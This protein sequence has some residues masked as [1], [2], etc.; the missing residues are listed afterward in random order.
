[1]SKV[2]KLDIKQL[3]ILDAL[4]KQRNLSR[5]AEQLGLTQQAISEHLKKL[6]HSFDDPLF[7]RQSNGVLP[8]A[9]AE[10][11]AHKVANIINDIDDLLQ[12]EQ[13]DPSKLDGIFTICATD[14]GQSVIL[15]PLLHELR[16]RAPKLKIIVRDFEIEQLPELLATGAIDL[17]VSF[18]DFVPSSCPRLTLFTEQHI[19]V[20]GRDNA[21]PDKLWSLKDIAPLPQLVISPKRPNLKGSADTWFEQQGFKRNIIMSVPFFATAADCIAST[22]AIAF[23]PSKLLPHPKLT[24]LQTDFTLPT[25]DVI[26]AWHK[27]S[28]QDPL[29]IWL[30]SVLQQ[31]SQAE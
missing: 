5:V 14:Y 25:F 10:G 13:F 22:D 11:L 2:H 27:R 26:A 12:P 4:L 28:D 21:L 29:N 8:T 23:L 20:T 17:V 16:A 19:C 15:P 7:I 9:F 30:R 6:R 31:T 1:M 3:V 18:P 24:Q